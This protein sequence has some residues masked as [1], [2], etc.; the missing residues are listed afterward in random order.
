MV[1]VMDWLPDD[2]I[3]HLIVDTVVV[4]PLMCP[5]RH[6]HEPSIAYLE[7]AA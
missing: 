5:T 3:V 1:N 7:R 4:A 2:D 6:L